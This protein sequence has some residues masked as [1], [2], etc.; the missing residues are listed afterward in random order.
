MGLLSSCVVT[1]GIVGF[2]VYARDSI[3]LVKSTSYMTI[4]VATAL[5]PL[6]HDTVTV[7]DAISEEVSTFP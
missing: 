4:P 3:G 1:V 2:G 7:P 6:A 5:P